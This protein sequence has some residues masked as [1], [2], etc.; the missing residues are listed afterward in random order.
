MTPRICFNLFR[1]DGQFHFNWNGPALLIPVEMKWTISFLHTPSN[2]RDPQ[3]N[4]QRPSIYPPDNFQ[5]PPRHTYCKTQ[6]QDHSLWQKLR[7]GFFLPS[8]LYMEKQSQLL[9]RSIEFEISCDVHTQIPF[10]VYWQPPLKMK[11][12]KC[13]NIKVSNC[14]QQSRKSKELCFKFI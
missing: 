2:S 8:F 3:D 14:D 10:S 12:V 13:E 5:T 7:S 1:P 6:M 11:C 9:L 4:L